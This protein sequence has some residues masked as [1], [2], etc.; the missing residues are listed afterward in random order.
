[1]RGGRSAP[2]QVTVAEGDGDAVVDDVTYDRVVVVIQLGDLVFRV[3]VHLQ[4]TAVTHQYV[5]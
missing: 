1:M 5:S 4:T 2:L 3:N